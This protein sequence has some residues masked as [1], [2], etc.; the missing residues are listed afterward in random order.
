MGNG[1][2][3]GVTNCWPESDNEMFRYIM[4]EYIESG[5]PFSLYFMTVSG[6][7]AY[8]LTGNSM[9]LKHYDIVKD[10]D[11]SEVIK[12]YHAA[13]YDLELAM[14]YLI[15]AL[16]DVGIAD[17][18]VIVISTDHYPYGLENSA[19]WGTDRDYLSELYG[20]PANSNISRDHSALIMW[21]GC[22]EEREEPIVVSDPVYSLDI[23][24]TLS[25]L[26][27]VEYDSRLLSGRD[28]FSDAEPLVLWQNYSWKTDKGY[29]NSPTGVFTPADG[30]VIE[31]GYIERIKSVVRNKFT[32]AKGLLAYDF[33]GLIFGNND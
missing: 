16:E 31:D 3:G 7:C 20:Y 32:F 22:L 29:Y 15:G 5:K 25:N 19:A 1:M 6:H 11:A 28:V 33:Y 17:D 10:M 21:C 12:C 24:P 18:T 9:S 13:N 4:P 27:G 14:E 26:F 8:S 30:A 2:E 23:V